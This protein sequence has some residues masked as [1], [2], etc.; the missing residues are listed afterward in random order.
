[1]K[2]PPCIGACN[3]G[4]ACP[5]REQRPPHGSGIVLAVIWGLACWASL[6]YVL[7]A[8]IGEASK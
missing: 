5:H 3:Q 1:M 7:V 4:R 8:V 2:C 6:A